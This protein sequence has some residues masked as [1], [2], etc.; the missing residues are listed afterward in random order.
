MKFRASQVFKTKV[1]MTS[2]ANATAFTTYAVYYISQLG[3]NP[4]ELLLVG[5]VLEATVLI[6]EELR[7]WLPIRMAGGCRLLPGCW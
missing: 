3:L 2:L 7:E 6:F 4:F 5:T 1:F